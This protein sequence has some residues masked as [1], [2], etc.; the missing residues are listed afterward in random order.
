MKTTIATLM[1]L[2]LLASMVTARTESSPA[3]LQ[4]ARTSL[5]GG[6]TLAL[7]PEERGEEEEWFASELPENPITLPGTTDL[8]GKGSALDEETMTYPVDFLDTAWPGR[9]A[10]ERI[11]EAGH[12]VRRH[13]YLGHAWYQRTIRVQ[14]HE[15]RPYQLLLERVCWS[16]KVWLDDRLVGEYDSLVAEHRYDLGAVTPGV[17]R[18]TVRVSNG[19]VHNI[20]LIGHAYGPETQSRWNGILGRIELIPRAPVF[21][22][23]VQ[24][25]PTPNRRSVRIR[26]RIADSTGEGGGVVLGWKVRD[27]ADTEVLGAGEISVRAGSAERSCEYHLPLDRPGHPWG[28][29]ISPRYVLELELR[30][31]GNLDHREVTF[32]FRDLRR[33]GRHVLLDGQRI[34]LRG[35]LDCC[36][37]PRTGHPPMTVEE[38]EEN[39]RTVREHG[40]NHVRFHTW[41]PPDAAFEAADRLGMYLA[42]ETAFWVDDWTATVGVR[43]QRLGE[44]PAITDW[45]RAEIGRISEAYGNHPSFA[46]FCIG[47]EFG[48]SGDWEVVDD[49]LREAKQADPRR[50]YNGSTARRRVEADD[51]WVTHRTTT[52]V[53]GVGPPHTNWD[54]SEG[55]AAT[56]LPV[57]AHETG[58]RPVFPDYDDLL[59]KFTGPLAPFNYTR[60]RDEIVAA[61]MG[62]QVADF[63]RA[64]GRFQYVQYKAE[65]E[66]FHRTPDMLGYQLLMLNDFTGQSEALVGILD[67]FWESKGIVTDNEVREWNSIVVPL[68]RFD[69]YVWTSDEV[70][71]AEIEVAN[72]F[73]H[74]LDDRNWS[75]SVREKNGTV[76]ARGSFPD[77]PVPRGALTRLGRLE[78]PLASAEDAAALE[79]VVG[80]SAFRNRWNLWVVPPIGEEPAVSETLVADECDEAVRDALAA[81]RDVLLLVH[82]LENDFAQR[83][84]FLS[85]YW[86]A[87]WWGDRFSSLGILCDPAHPA[88]ARFPNEGHS[89]WQWHELTEGATTI[90]LDGAPADYRPIVQ[91]VTDFH[92]NRLLGQV[93]EAR[94]GEGRLLVCGYDLESDLEHRHAARQFR[95]SL[96]K[97]LNS[98]EFQPKYELPIEL[99]TKW[100]A[101]PA[102]APIVG[103]D[104]VDVANAALHVR[105]AARLEARDQNVAWNLEHDH[106]VRRTDGYAWRIGGGTWQDERGAAWHGNPL[107]VTLDVPREAA[108]TLYLHFHD[109]NG[110]GRRGTIE[111]EGRSTRLPAHDGAGVWVALP[112]E[113]TDTIDGEVTLIAKPS[114]G[115]NLMITE[116][117]FVPGS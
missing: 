54:F 35:T 86:S 64:S 79:L 30:A 37:Y 77:L 87:K 48:M 7:D 40:F 23:D 11:D 72:Y 10:V 111:F 67:P 3:D 105:S 100:L 75:W 106:A 84:G 45:V 57:V 117:V 14:E 25:Y 99:I 73:H 74:D 42:P 68:A 110:L 18:L 50:L 4:R 107:S 61:G 113:S 108:G 104:E 109:W 69:R 114:A 62:D 13:M 55:V 63:A 38:W 28:E 92:H 93:F 52:A 9:G 51:F 95:R 81:G 29:S 94:V 53:R 65:H 24:V 56:D 41:C 33:D 34:F 91:P 83:T 58:Q 22:R 116:L 36:V 17:H 49:I 82:G 46:F 88:L 115:P 76:M 103:V 80:S 97:Y 98:E 59:P 27:Q 21:L 96:V 44:D 8:A 70:F 60:L 102:A 112:V 31:A 43:P 26:A 12:L 47:N 1:T 32:G 6:W 101:P 15:A 89:D 5:A 16:S 66:A 2:G 71:S 20:G 90:D 19:L 78:V 85:A 39:L